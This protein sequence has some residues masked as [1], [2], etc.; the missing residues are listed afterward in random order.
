[1]QDV[2]QGGSGGLPLS[3]IEEGGEG[4]RGGR[5]GIRR[6]SSGCRMSL[7]GGANLWACHSQG[8]K[9]DKKKRVSGGWRMWSRRGGVEGGVFFTSVASQSV[10]IFFLS[11]AP[12]R[13]SR[14]ASNLYP[15]WSPDVNPHQQQCFFLPPQHVFFLLVLLPPALFAVFPRLWW[16]HKTILPLCTVALSRADVSII[17]LPLCPSF[18][19][20]FKD[21]L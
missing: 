11:C 13:A 8:M 4:G 7:K 1:M 21:W 12:E 6:V 14:N 2:A 16:S 3:I 18:V 20:K 15:G 9:E 19:R 5:D 17:F 10:Y